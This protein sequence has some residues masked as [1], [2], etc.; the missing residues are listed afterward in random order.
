M[1]MPKVTII[2]TTYNRCRFVCAAVESVLAQNF[3]DAEI[4]VVDDGSRDDTYKLLK[5]YG[6]SIHYIY[7]K[8]KGRSAARNSGIRLSRGEYIAFLDDDDIWLPG[9][10]ESQVAFLDSHPVCALAHTFTELMDERGQPLRKE[11][12]KHLR[13]YRRALRLGYAYEVISRMCLMYTSS[14]V[15]RRRC[16]DKAGLFDPLMEAFEDWD[17][18]LR[19]ALKYEI[20]V[21]PEPLVRIRIHTAH[22]TQDEF[23]RGRINI[24]RKHLA[25]L[26]SLEDTLSC[27]RARHNFYLQLARAYYIRGDV[28]KSRENIILALRLGLPFRKRLAIEP[29]LWGILLFPGPVNKLRQLKAASGLSKGRDYPQRIIPLETTGGPLTSHIKRYE[30]AARFCREKVVLD[31]ACGVGYGSSFLASVVRE[32]TGVDVSPEAIAYAKEH[33]QKE[34]TRFEIMDVCSL[35]F[36]DRYFDLVCSFETL[37]HLNEPLK[38]LA[39]IKRVLKE[40]GVLIISTPNVKR[41]VINPDNPY[42]KVEFSRKDFNNI[43]RKHFS[44]VEIFGQRRRQSPAHYWIQKMDVFHLRGLLSGALRRKVCHGLATNS[45]DEAGLDDFII[46]KAMINRAAELIGVCR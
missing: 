31:A 13:V 34:N 23:T 27:R 1:E 40:G 28:Q 21:I 38:F 39:Q 12:K 22:S 45:W 41:T 30:F 16:L 4:I 33:Y 24:S 35:N 17:I 11:T 3:R 14:V 37:E 29:N 2:I 26:D 9:K 20:A 10:L 36:P 6:S 44:R 8:N 15:M 43:L 18:Y 32:V 42:H 46:S 25:I 19:F 5:R 7:Q